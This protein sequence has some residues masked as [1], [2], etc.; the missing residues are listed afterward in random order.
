MIFPF[1]SFICI[2]FLSLGISI[3]IVAT[4]R[5]WK[6]RGTSGKA[7]LVF[8]SMGSKDQSEWATIPSI[9]VTNCVILGKL[10]KLP[11]SQFLIYKMRKIKVPPHR[12]FVRIQWENACTVMFF[13][14]LSI[15]S[16]LPL[17][18]QV[19][20]YRKNEASGFKF[21]FSKSNLR[22]S[23]PKLFSID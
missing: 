2:K 1:M 14:K 9:P 3:N 4:R 21:R 13:E 19:A 15:R 5:K 17:R 11:I 23:V 18:S 6:N 12:I 8:N 10:L 7:N 16:R 22:A 20:N